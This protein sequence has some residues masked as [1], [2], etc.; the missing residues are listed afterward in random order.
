MLEALAVKYTL[1]CDTGEKNA[2]VERTWDGGTGRKDRECGVI[3]EKCEGR[4]SEWYGY[5][6]GRL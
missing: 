6:G 3:L 5:R 4:R 2:L 1:A